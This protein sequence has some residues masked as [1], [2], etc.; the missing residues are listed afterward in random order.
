MK[1]YGRGYVGKEKPNNL[2]ARPTTL[3][4]INIFGLP[5]VYS[6]KQYCPEVK[7]QGQAGTCTAFSGT[8]YYKLL[9][10]KN[11]GKI[12][13]LSERHIY[14]N[15]LLADAF[16]GNNYEGT[17]L[18]AILNCFKYYGCC[19]AID[20]VYNDQSQGMPSTA[21]YMKH[22]L[23]FRIKEYYWAVNDGN[24][25]HDVLA[26]KK[27]IVAYKGL[28]CAFQLPEDFENYTNGTIKNA[29]I[30]PEDCHAMLVVGYDDNKQAFQLLNSWS[31]DW[32]E[33]GFCWIDYTLFHNMI[34]A[35]FG[36]TI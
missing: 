7:S 25:T 31:K 15:A 18:D 33:A 5:K 9:Y 26:I 32:G 21:D 3:Q 29:N 2:T 8:S 35:G 24:T 30:V 6:V 13:D 4:T 16:E 11:K 34:I 28:Y 27:A 1:K 19:P 10:K 22:G 36:M 17:T 12:I 20:W 23:D 14:E